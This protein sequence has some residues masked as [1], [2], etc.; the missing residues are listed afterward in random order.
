[1]LS[2]SE[3]VENSV[4]LSNALR[5]GTT[6]VLAAQIENIQNQLVNNRGLF[7]LFLIDKNM[8]IKCLHI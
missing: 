8:Y 6:G 7:L 1:M 4:T 5:N 3:R 2:N